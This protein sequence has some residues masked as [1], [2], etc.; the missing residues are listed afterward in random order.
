MVI[1]TVPISLTLSPYIPGFMS[2]EMQVA[3]KKFIYVVFA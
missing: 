2:L 1:L 3:C